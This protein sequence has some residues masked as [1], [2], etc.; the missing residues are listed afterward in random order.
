MVDRTQYLV[1]LVVRWRARVSQSRVVVHIEIGS[2]LSSIYSNIWN[3]HHSSWLTA[4]PH[5]RFAS[6]VALGASR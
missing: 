5:Y 3:S 4:H 6:D 2:E 1:E